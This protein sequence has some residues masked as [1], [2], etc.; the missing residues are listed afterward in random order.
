MVER[1]GIS[2]QRRGLAL[3]LVMTGL[4]MVLAV[5][6]C[7]KPVDAYLAL[8]VEVGQVSTGDLEPSRLQVRGDTLFVSYNGLPRIDAFNF[9]LEIVASLAL[10]APETIR[11][12]AFAITDTSIVVADHGLGVVA[13]FDRAGHFQTSFDTLPD[14]KTRLQPIALV[15]FRGIV[16]VVDMGAHQV[17]AISL[18]DMPDVTETGELIL[19]IPKPGETPLVFPSAVQ[20][21][22]D[23]RLLVG[24]AGGAE[25]SVFT[26]E[27]SRI[28]TFEPVPEISKMAPQGFAYDRLPD[29]SMVDDSSFDPSGVRAQGRIHLAD[30][31][32]G[33]IH[34]YNPV[35]KY[36]G[37]Y[38]ETT[39]L[40]GPAGIAT[41]PEGEFLFVSDPPARRILV[42]RLKGE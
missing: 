35:G 39:R 33:R 34:M 23:G 11:P 1:R 41:D 24:D 21:T 38:P 10:Q 36:L 6:G 31:Y 27:G 30:G 9:D 29:P 13:V 32:N 28:Y 42:Y 26:C 4:F 37:S 19:S 2:V 16:Y 20:I 8:P 5:G 12:T 7:S 40:A 15:A 17:F 25:V 14:G 3:A 22:P 18:N